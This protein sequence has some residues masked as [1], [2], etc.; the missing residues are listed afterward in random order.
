MKRRKITIIL[1]NRDSSDREELILQVEKEVKRLTIDLS[2]TDKNEEINVTE[3]EGNQSEN[4]QLKADKPE[5][6]QS[7][8][9]DKEVVRDDV[10]EIIAYDTAEEALNKNEDENLD[11]KKEDQS[12]QKTKGWKRLKKFFKDG[13]SLTVSALAQGVTEGLKD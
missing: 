8:E 11:Q 12:E 6:N 4:T 9:I 2:S 3:Q 10:A 1:E 5:N 13:Y 7:E